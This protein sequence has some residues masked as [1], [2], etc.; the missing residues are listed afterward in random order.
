[1]GFSAFFKFFAAPLPLPA[2]IVIS[3]YWVKKRRSNSKNN[4][5]ERTYNSNWDMYVEQHK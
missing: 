2:I 5:C 3:T 1:M 4:S